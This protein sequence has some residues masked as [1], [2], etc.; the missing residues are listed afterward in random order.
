MSASDRIDALRLGYGAFG[1]PFV[2]FTLTYD[3]PLLSSGNKPKNDNK[4]TIRKN[5]HPQFIDLWSSHPALQT[6]D[7]NRHFPKIGG[8]VLTQTHHQHP[9]P[10]YP[11]IQAPDRRRGADY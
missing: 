1:A 7:Q 9:G 3:G 10:I 8:A 4:W 11:P 5:M 2:K 6:V